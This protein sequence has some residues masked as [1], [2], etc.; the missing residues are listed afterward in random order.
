MAQ[1]PDLS[2]DKLDPPSRVRWHCRRGML[3]LDLLLLRFFD[4][5]YAM[6]SKADQH[7]FQTLLT[8]HDPILFAWLMGQAEPQIK[9]LA[10]MVSA[11]R[12]Y[13]N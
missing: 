13:S 12:D 8:Y 3:E 7:T 2:A 10:D 6:L 1:P 9:A 4:G 5:R 11:I